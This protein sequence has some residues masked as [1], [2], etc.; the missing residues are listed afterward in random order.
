MRGAAGAAAPVP[1]EPV[2]NRDSRHGAFARVLA[3]LRH[4]SRVCQ[5]GQLAQPAIPIYRLARPVPCRGVPRP[6]K[7]E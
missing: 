2:G 6:G 5:P 1:G 3:L 7:A 4:A